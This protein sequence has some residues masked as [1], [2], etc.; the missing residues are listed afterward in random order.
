MTTE[1]DEILHPTLSRDL[2]KMLESNIR[3]SRHRS[4]HLGLCHLGKSEQQMPLTLSINCREEAKALITSFCNKHTA[5]QNFLKEYDIGFEVVVEQEPAQLRAT[6][7][8]SHRVGLDVYQDP[9][10]IF[11]PNDATSLCGLRLEWRD[12]AGTLRYFACGGVLF[13]KG[14]LLALT[15]RHGFEMLETDN[16]ILSQH[17]DNTTVH[18]VKDN[19]EDSFSNVRVVPLHPVHHSWSARDKSFDYDW[20]F[21]ELPP[22]L[23]NAG[24]AVNRIGSEVIRGFLQERKVASGPVSI[25]LGGE[26]LHGELGT[27]PET[28]SCNDAMYNVR[29]IILSGD[30]PLPK[31]ASGAWVI[32]ATDEGPLL[33]GYIVAAH[34]STKG[35]FMIP[36][37]E[38]LKDIREALNVRRPGDLRVA[39]PQDLSPRLVA[40]KL[41]SLSH[42]SQ[43]TLI[44]P[45]SSRSKRQSL[46]T[47]FLSRKTSVEVTAQDLHHHLMPEYT[48]KSTSDL[49]HS[50]SFASES[51]I[52]REL[53]SSKAH[54]RNSVSTLG[55]MRASLPL[56]GDMQTRGNFSHIDSKISKG[57]LLPKT[58][59][60][61]V[62]ITESGVELESPNVRQLR[63]MGDRAAYGAVKASLAERVSSKHSYVQFESW[64]VCKSSPRRVIETY[65]PTP[66]SDWVSEI[67]QMILR[68]R[69]EY[70]ADFHLEVRAEVSDIR[71]ER[72]GIRRNPAITPVDFCRS[73]L[74]EN[75]RQNWKH[76][77]Y[78]PRLK[79]DQI[80]TSPMIIEI[81]HLWRRNTWYKPQRLLSGHD[82]VKSIRTE[83]LR[84]FAIMIYIDLDPRAIYNFIQSGLDDSKLPLHRNVRPPDIT[85]E[86]YTSFL[87]H[88]HK[89]LPVNFDSHWSRDTPKFITDEAIIPILSD[90][91][92]FQ[93]GSGCYGKTF[94]VTIDPEHC[95]AEFQRTRA[96]AIK[97]LPTDR[98]HEDLASS[99]M[100][101]K[102]TQIRHTHLSDLMAS[103][104]QND[105]F[106][107]LSP[108]ADMNLDQFFRSEPSPTLH[109]D[110]VI[111]FWEQ[112]AGLSD[113]LRT[114][115]NLVPT[116]RVFYDSQ[117]ETSKLR[118]WHLDLKPE[119][120]LVF[121]EPQEVVGVWKITDFGISHFK[122]QDD[123]STN[124]D[125]SGGYSAPE[126]SLQEYS[127]RASDVWSFGCILLEVMTW[128]LATG[129]LCDEF[130]NQRCQA[131][132]K[133]LFWTGGKQP[134][135]KTAVQTVMRNLMVQC[136]SRGVFEYLFLETK[137][138]ME[139]DPC[140]RPRASDIANGFDALLTQAK[141]D[142]EDDEFYLLEK[143][144]TS[145]FVA[146]PCELD[147]SSMDY[148]CDQYNYRE[149]TRRPGTNGM[150]SRHDSN[151]AQRCE[152]NT[153]LPQRTDPPSFEPP[154]RRSTQDAAVQTDPIQD[155]DHP[156]LPWLPVL[157]D[158]HLQSEPPSIDYRPVSTSTNPISSAAAALRPWDETLVPSASSVSSE[159]QSDSQSEYHTAY[160]RT[161]SNASRASLLSFSS[162]T[163][164]SHA[165]DDGHGNADVLQGLT[166]EPAC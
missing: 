156:P 45:R 117:D 158:D 68:F 78:L 65:V 5:V 25:V 13:V 129:P 126:V 145:K 66:D 137:R 161:R 15:T 29:S 58:I 111:G 160:G 153:C 152:S 92:E 50:K 113:A 162:N 94:R 76:E 93:L 144:N 104:V 80:V 34:D 9:C 1:Y 127:T 55:S 19:T 140:S 95:D 24:L 21:I 41:A 79:L 70:S 159:S 18:S 56:P 121:R 98:H 59:E 122:K 128:I 134:Q 31:C 28:I 114:I 91:N 30:N 143:F 119:N 39:Q 53:Q 141:F 64:S 87:D 164:V 63:W 46:F 69:G 120:I 3:E 52:S 40:S 20:K 102:S 26:I 22:S 47:R 155:D 99:H 14:K 116:H 110:S 124:I 115:H 54:L 154:S 157:P 10:R 27:T 132:G 74:S 2:F 33:C 57:P 16:Q 142:L 103:W 49:C 165:D 67:Q 4:F 8:S 108:A 73:M 37:W 123:V 85:Q 150:A 139:I 86:A 89:F 163:S 6:S 112:L 60:C 17:L 125:H 131:D 166:V 138:M 38:A 88:Q 133:A 147:A 135:L 130:R 7:V 51:Q 82:M 32:K 71:S 36:I 136:E 105:S 90:K 151:A 106:Y 35:A 72:S 11:V 77:S 81:V 84:M 43:P 148:P 61:R 62:S 48:S 12:R 109:K 83:H 100:L 146:P 97:R 149:T 23:L 75:M 107:M 96:F 44:E 101:R 42:E 118:G